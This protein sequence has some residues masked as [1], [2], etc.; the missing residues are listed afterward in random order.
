MLIESPKISSDNGYT[1][2]SSNIH[3]EK[4]NYNI[5]Y[6][7]NVEIHPSSDIFLVACLIPA[8]K[9]GEDLI[10]EGKISKQ[11]YDS[12]D[13]IQYIYSSWY[14][15]YSKIK[16]ISKIQSEYENKSK[17]I[18][19]FFSGGVDSFYTLI[20]RIKEIDKIVLVHGFDIPI[21]D[22]QYY[23]EVSA[24]IKVIANYFGKELI[25]VQTNIRDFSN[26]F[27][28]WGKFYSGI[29]AV[30]ILLS[31]IIGK[32]YIPSGFTRD[33][34]VSWG[35][36]PDLDKYWST[37]NVEI[38]YDELIS[39]I[40]KIKEIHTNE[41]FLNHVRVCWQCRGY[42]CS[43]CDKC[44][45]TMIALYAFG[46]LDKCKTFTLKEPILNLIPKINIHNRLY[47]L[48][49]KEN[50]LPMPNGDVKNA[51]ELLIEKYKSKYELND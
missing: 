9:L 19:T 39:R 44:I 49:H 6:K 29:P 15:E 24:N 42:N 34:L 31:K 21:L 18:A 25:E 47:Y 43:E 48:L 20:K 11:L 30:S 46:V 32:I 16:I 36:H 17:F 2:I 4:R 10:V 28:E 5:W 14:P 33:N 3:T 50:I 41:I 35:S 23:S 26:Q 8:M 45:R 13:E 37:E 40:D 27:S 1:I 38:I 7:T 22:T 51:L 12:I